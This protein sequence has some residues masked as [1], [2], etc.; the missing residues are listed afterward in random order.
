MDSAF[1]RALRGGIK[2][3]AM[4][5]DH[6]LTSGECFQLQPG[7]LPVRCQLQGPTFP[8][9][10][11]LRGAAPSGVV[12]TCWTRGELRITGQIQMKSLRIEAETLDSVL[13][14]NVSAQKGDGAGFFVKGDADISDGGLIF[15]KHASARSGG[16]FLAKEQLH[17]TSHSTITIQHAT[18]A[19]YGGG[20]LAGKG[21]QGVTFN[22]TE[23]GTLQ[24]LSP[25]NLQCSKTFTVSNG[26]TPRCDCGDYRILCINRSYDVVVFYT[27]GC[28][29]FVDE[30]PEEIPLAYLIAADPGFSLL[31]L[32]V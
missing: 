28:G 2:G 19:E 14:E 21:L 10:A 26:L 17:L 25:E 24:A 23:D 32:L 5:L 6:E 7:A 11:Q 27:F 29:F 31:A 30:W 1:A 9:P 22:A 20:I 13:I 16:G 8:A 3:V 4:V 12:T 15:I 18:A